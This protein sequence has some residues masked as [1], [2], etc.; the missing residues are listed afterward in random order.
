M[1]RARQRVHRERV[2]WL[3]NQPRQM[4]RR[5]QARDREEQMHARGR[6]RGPALT[7]HVRVVRVVIWHALLIW[8]LCLDDATLGR[9]SVCGA[10][11]LSLQLAFIMTW[12]RA[13]SKLHE[14]LFVHDSG[15]DAV[16]GHACT[17]SGRVVVLF[18]VCVV[19]VL[20]VCIQLEINL[21]SAPSVPAGLDM[22]VSLL[23]RRS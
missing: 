9:P 20:A 10:V 21:A 17:R 1:E 14:A 15:T 19:A 3:Q 5:Q 7:Q 12:Q 13:L 22:L 16:A 4:V 23:M 8:P 6:Q 18:A 11:I 2:A